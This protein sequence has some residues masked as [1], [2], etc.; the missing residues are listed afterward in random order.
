MNISLHQ[1]SETDAIITL[2][3]D[4]SDYQ[5]KVSTKL[6]EYA[7]KANIKGFRQGMVPAG[8][9]KKMVGKSILMEEINHIISHSIT[10]YIKEKKI[11]V[12]G[13]PMPYQ[14]RQP[15]IDWDFQK[16]FEFVFQVGMA[17]DFKVDLSPNV[18]ISKY[19]IEVD[20]AVLQETLAKTRERYSKPNY[21]E[22]EISEVTD[23]LYGEIEN[24]NEEAK[25]NSSIIIR[26]VKA[27]EQ[28]K[29]IG[30]K[31]D[32]II[33][34]DALQI[35]EDAEDQ[36]AAL[37]LG[38]GELDGVDGKVSVKI[39]FVNRTVPAEF[40]QEL[41]DQVFGKDAVSTEEDFINKVKE[42]IAVNYE[43]ETDH[44]LDHEI[45]HHLMD[46]TSVNLPDEFL[47]RW[48]KITGD[49]TITD[50]VLDKEFNDYKKSI[51]LDLIKAQIAEENNIKVETKE[52]QERA[53]MMVL[54]QFGGQTYAMQLMDRMDSIAENYLKGNNGQNFMKLYNALR[55]EK[56]MSAIKSLITISEKQV[57]LEEFKKEVDAHRH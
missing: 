44:L 20:D 51:K 28:S 43:R 47:K 36:A 29:F 8:V 19:K 35:L 22:I 42:S 11:K 45:D 16:D 55:T 13:D 39:T 10:D 38:P 17:A 54:S 52:V 24:A 3:L 41:F 46:T 25:K 18:N 12:L 6:K 31:K 27:S 9:V 21:S 48:L 30:L 56:I 23:I 53:K 37:G 15:T 5:L 49:G 57:S 33:E 32:D 26:K 1:Q 14:E 40:N 2:K 4:E 34:F 50:D 7:K